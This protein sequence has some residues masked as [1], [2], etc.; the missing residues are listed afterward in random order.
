M[1]GKSDGSDI[2]FTASDGVTKL[3]HEIESY[4]PNTGQLTAWVSLPVLSTTVD[5]ALYVY[6]GNPSAPNQQNPPGVWDST[7]A[8]VWHL[9]DNASSIVVADSSQGGDNANARAFTNLK[10]VPGQIGGALTFDGVSDFVVAPNTTGIDIPTNT[11]LTTESWINVSAFTTTSQVLGYLIGKGNVGSAEAYFV[12]M[13]ND[14]G[15]LNLKGGMVNNSTFSATWPISGWTTG[16]WHHVVSSWDGANWNLFF[17][18]ALKAQLPTANGPLKMGLP[19]TFGGESIS[20]TIAGLLACSLDE[21]RISTVARSPSWIATE[22]N[23]QS[24]PA[25][26]YTVGA[27]QTP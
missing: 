6:F 10:S 22:Y 16:T 17:D 1:V 3:S 19:L 14:A 21:I 12:R 24:S 15:T 4:N 20:G 26:F 25:S 13:E 23:N 8:G 2:L 5:T 11:P 9:S 18:G 27:I 7:F